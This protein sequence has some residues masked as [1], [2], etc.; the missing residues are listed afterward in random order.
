[1]IEPESIPSGV[2]FTITIFGDNIAK[3]NALG[4]RF[5]T[6]FEVKAVWISKHEIQC[7][8]PAGQPGEILVSLTVNGHDYTDGVFS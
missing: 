3:T 4:C 6:K 2:N 5:G 1:M 7:N 8:A